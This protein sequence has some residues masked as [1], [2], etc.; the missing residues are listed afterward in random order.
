MLLH[1]NYIELEGVGGHKLKSHIG[2]STVAVALARTTFPNSVLPCVQSRIYTIY[3]GYSNPGDG[4]RVVKNS[5]D[6]R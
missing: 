5:Q 3:G 1:T 6:Y 2:S 4:R